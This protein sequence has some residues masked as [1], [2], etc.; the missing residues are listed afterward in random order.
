MTLL[1]E[2][3]WIWRSPV[4]PRSPVSTSRY[5]RWTHQDLLCLLQG[6]AREPTR[7]E[8]SQFQGEKRPKRCEAE[9]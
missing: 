6:I 4:T 8:H 9:L 5:C 1:T 7:L 3:I 2:R